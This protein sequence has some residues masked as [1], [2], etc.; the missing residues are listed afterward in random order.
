MQNVAVVEAG[1]DE[2]VLRRPRDAYTRMLIRSVPSLSPRR[3]TARE[4]GGGA[5]NQALNKT[6]PPVAVYGAP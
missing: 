1:G 5:A 3:A 4:F 6:T 2:D